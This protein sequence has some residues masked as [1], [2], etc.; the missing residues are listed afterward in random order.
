MHVAVM[1]AGSLGSLLGGLLAADHRVTLVG[2]ED[3]LRAVAEHGLAITG[4]VD[5]TVH[6]AATTAW[7]AVDEVD[8][9]LLTVKS[10]DTR[11]A[12]EAL[13][14]SPPP[15]VLSVQNGLGNGAILERIL[16]HR[17][18]V[19]V[20]TA[21]YGARLA[22]PG[23]VRCTGRGSLVFGTPD[24]SRSSTAERMAEAWPRSLDCRHADRMPRRLWEKVIVNAAIN[25]VT[26][27]AGVRNGRILE[28]PLRPIAMAAAREA[29]AVA[30]RDDFDFETEEVLDTVRSVAENTAD[31][32][33]SMARD[34]RRGAR[35]EIEAITG[36]IIDR[37][38]ELDI[39]VNRVLYGLIAGY[40]TDVDAD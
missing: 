31:N 15:T 33:S 3:H 20:G 24:G 36:A 5:R 16:G 30:R 26:A 21:T 29:V 38:A 22:D 6:P 35:T 9:C 11:S 23:T 12:A 8:I 19:L 17:C 25:P 1:G 13:R 40:E 14:E 27:L 39:P 2:R 34:V 32:E 4:Q 18:E 28:D 10:Y 37:A 7:S